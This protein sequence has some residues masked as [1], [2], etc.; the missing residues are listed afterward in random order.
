MR[1]DNAFGHTG[2]TAGILVHGDIVEGQFHFRR[3]RLIF[4]NAI[5][6]AIHVRSRFD[7]GE[8]EFFQFFTKKSLNRIQEVP[9]AHINN[10]FDFCFRPQI[11][12]AVPE[13][14]ERNQNLGIGVCK[15]MFQFGIGIERII[16]N[17][18]RTDL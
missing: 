6:P 4:F 3:I 12:H 10:L 16:Q 18:N 1:Q 9:D 13:G 7:I 17:N 11:N 5:H 14:I 2:R 15:L 8:G